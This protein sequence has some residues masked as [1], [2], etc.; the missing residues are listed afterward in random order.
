MEL[1]K[2]IFNESHTVA[3]ATMEEIQSAVDSYIGTRLY[4]DDITMGLEFALNA[5]VDNS[6]FEALASL[7]VSDDDVTSH[8]EISVN[9]TEQLRKAQSHARQALASFSKFH[10]SLED[11]SHAL[12]SATAIDPGI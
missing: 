6:A 11:L 9:K 4:E 12:K 3:T 10:E 5:I 2:R 8:S 7:F 1:Y